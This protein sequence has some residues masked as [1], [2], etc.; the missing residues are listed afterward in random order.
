MWREV[1]ESGK[2]CERKNERERERDG[3]KGHNEGGV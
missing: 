1:K 2:N 3:S